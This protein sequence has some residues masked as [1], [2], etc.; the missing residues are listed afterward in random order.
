MSEPY[1][2]VE[3][4]LKGARQEIIRAMSSLNMEPESLEDVAEEDIYLSQRDRWASHA[5]EHLEAAFELLESVLTPP[6]ASA[7][8]SVDPV[9]GFRI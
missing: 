8:I 4:P 7:S 2:D 6:M 9:E 5:M 3:T 1:L